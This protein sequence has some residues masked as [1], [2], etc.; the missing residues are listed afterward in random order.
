[1]ESLETTV[2]AFIARKRAEVKLLASYTE[3]ESG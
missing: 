1:M 2:I 3:V